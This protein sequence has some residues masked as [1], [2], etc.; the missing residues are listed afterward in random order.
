MWLA[1]GITGAFCFLFGLTVWLARKEGSKSAQL[2][3]Q[4]AQ[5]RKD[6]EEAKR[7]KQITDNVYSLPADDARHRLH[8]IANQQR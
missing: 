2:D 7:A 5:Q 3:A 6:A 4:L 1:F 8:E